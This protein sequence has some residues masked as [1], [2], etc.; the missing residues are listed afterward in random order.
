MSGCG[1][2]S[3]DPVGTGTTDGGTHTIVNVGGEVEAYVV[4]TGPNPFQIRTFESSD[5]SVD[6]ALGAGGDTIDL[7]V[8]TA[9]IVSL[10][11]IGL[12][13]EVWVDTTGP[14]PFEL[15]SVRSPLGSVAVVQT[16]DEVQLEVT[17][18]NVGLFIQVYVAGSTGPFQW[19]SFQSS[20]NSVSIVQ[21]LTDIDFTVDI[22]SLMSLAN[23]GTGAEVWVDPSG[24]DPFNLR[25]IRS[26]L[27]T[28]QVV[29]TATEIQLEVTDPGGAWPVFQ[30]DSTATLL[31]NSSTFVTFVTLAG[32]V[33]VLD[34]AEWKINMCVLICV[35]DSVFVNAEVRWQIE[36]AVGVFTT[37]DQYSTFQ[38]ITIA[39]GEFSTPYHRTIKVTASMDTPRMRLQ[40]RRHDPGSTDYFFEHPRWGGAQIEPPP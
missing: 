37:I 38:E 32:D 34:G 36:T 6:V 11:N 23:V 2:C 17:G 33:K 40:V 20:D 25:S 21:N 3:C 22:E 19:R 4:G 13:A 16:A 35:P 31:T 7:T 29:E 15:R 12:G 18:E 1:T 9:G 27:G 24:P 26:P 14:N 28:V 8:D 10:L 39:V 30:V 5:N